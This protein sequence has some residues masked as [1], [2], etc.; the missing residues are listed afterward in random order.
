MPTLNDALL[1]LISP[2]AIAFDFLI[3]AKVF[4]LNFGYL[5]ISS[6]ACYVL[7]HAFISPY[8]SSRSDKGNSG[9]SKSGKGGE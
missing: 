3:S 1:V 2:F 5:L 8:V 7:V 9:S 6:F 4:G